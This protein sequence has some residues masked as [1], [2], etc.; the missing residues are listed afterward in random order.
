MTHQRADAIPL[1]R[2][3]ICSRC[4]SVQNRDSSVPF[5]SNFGIGSLGPGARTS[6]MSVT[7]RVSPARLPSSRSSPSSGAFKTTAG[8]DFERKSYLLLKMLLLACLSPSSAIITVF[9]AI[10][11]IPWFRWFAFPSWCPVDV[12]RLPVCLLFPLPPRSMSKYQST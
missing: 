2:K 7:Q 3:E 6:L 10:L 9:M 8:D 5:H 4:N 11:K 1:P 12:W